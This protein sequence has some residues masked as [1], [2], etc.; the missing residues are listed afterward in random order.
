MAEQ[1]SGQLA[2]Y[3]NSQINVLYREARQERKTQIDPWCHDCTLIMIGTRVTSV[4]YVE[5]SR[6]MNIKKKKVISDCLV[7]NVFYRV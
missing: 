4:N 7:R 6:Y 3:R 1:L 5:S 2:V